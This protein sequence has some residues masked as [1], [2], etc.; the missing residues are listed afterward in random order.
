[1]IPIKFPFQEMKLNKSFSKALPKLAEV[2]IQLSTCLKLKHYTI[3]YLKDFSKLAS[4]DLSHWKAVTIHGKVQVPSWFPS[5]MPSIPHLLSCILRKGS[6]PATPVY[7]LPRTTLR[8]ETLVKVPT[9]IHHVLVTQCR[10]IYAI[11]LL[12]TLSI[13]TTT[14][15]FIVFCRHCFLLHP[16]IMALVRSV[17]IAILMGCLRQA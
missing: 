2:L 7:Y 5:S 10:L 1:M 12:Y 15:L 8:M 13:R 3:I 16:V 14:T 6:P 4:L 11:S 17:F 9:C